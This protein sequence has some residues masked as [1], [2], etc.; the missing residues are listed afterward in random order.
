MNQ[1]LTPAC[2]YVQS[3]L[4]FQIRVLEMPGC[5]VAIM[6]RDRLVLET[7]YGYADAVHQNLLTPRH[8]FRI[9]SHSKSFT[10][11]GVMKLREAGRLRLDDPI[12]THV[13]DLHPEVSFDCTITLAQRRPAARCR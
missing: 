1:W 7:A 11:A 6:H 5:I 10:A 13:R 4:A 2:E 12:G 3:W 8:R 9:A